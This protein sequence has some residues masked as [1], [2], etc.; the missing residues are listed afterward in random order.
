MGSSLESS[1]WPG[2]RPQ[3]GPAA[4][5]QSE[6]Q[7][8]A[9]DLYT[10]ISVFPALPFMRLGLSIPQRWTLVPLPPCLSFPLSLCA[11]L[12][13]LGVGDFFIFVTWLALFDLEVG[14][15]WYHLG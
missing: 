13:S 5:A 8:S 9:A 1:A 15:E 11:E 10:L 6:T 4:H 3:V 14:R 2:W 7:A 12:G